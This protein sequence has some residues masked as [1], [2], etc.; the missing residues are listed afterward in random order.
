MWHTINEIN[1]EN[2]ICSLEQE[3]E[4]LA[5][6]YADTEPSAQSKSRNTQEKSC[7]NGSE[8]ESCQSF[9]SGT[10]CEH[11]T[12]NLGAE[13][14]MSSA[15]GFPARTFHAQEKERESTEN[16]AECGEK[17]RELLVKYDRNT[18]SWKT[19]LCLWEEDLPESSVILPRWGI[20]RDGVCWGRQTLAHRIDETE[21]GLSPN[22]QTFFHTP[23]TTGL[24]GGSNSRK[25]LKKRMQNLPTPMA[26][27]AKEMNSPSEANRNT[28][29]LAYL[30]GGK[31]NPEWIEWLMGWIIG[32]TDL[33]P[34]GMDKFQ[35]WQHS[36]GIL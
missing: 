17:W 18:H 9:Q 2:Y 25:A 30:V 33:K 14:S 27:M 7:C 20:M 8:T 28:P 16:A 15:E 26:H 31:V 4:S 22:G 12:V 11:S 13:K 36:H 19:H 34:L 21:S 10:M 1:L 3:E 29:T 23:T 35:Q 5:G 24:D 6:C 32:Q